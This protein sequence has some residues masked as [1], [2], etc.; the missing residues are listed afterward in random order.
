M[1][2][3]FGQ[4]WSFGYYVRAAEVRFY[5]ANF[6]LSPSN[7]TLPYRINLIHAP[8]YETLVNPYPV[9]PF[10][11]SMQYS[12]PSFFS[13]ISVNSTKDRFDVEIVSL[14]NGINFQ[15]FFRSYGIDYHLGLGKK[16]WTNTQAFAFSVNLNF[17]HL[18]TEP[19]SLFIIPLGSVV[20]PGRDYRVIYSRI[21]SYKK[22]Q[23]YWY[24]G[25]EGDL[26]RTISLF[27][28]YGSSFS[29]SGQSPYNVYNKTQ[30]LNFGFKMKSFK[31]FHLK[32]K[33]Y[34]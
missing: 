15:D 33:R 29:K 25:I 10:G 20:L 32:H 30:F 19:R 4:D 9:V 28:N 12:R 3:A 1:N 16:L 34:Y 8:L 23:L 14:Q 18:F 17:H 11:I 2:V 27:F 22:L 24:F 6:S 21:E 31:L 13:R 26:S 5:D 7:Q